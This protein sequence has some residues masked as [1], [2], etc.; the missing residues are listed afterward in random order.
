MREVEFVR[1]REKAA[2]LFEQVAELL[3]GH[4]EPDAAW[5]KRLA[6]AQRLL[7]DDARL[8]VVFTGEFSAGKTSL[9]S[10]LTGADLAIAAGPTTDREHTI[11]WRGLD[12]VDTPGVQADAQATDHDEI[13]RR[14]TVDAD[15]VLFVVT[16]ELFN[17]RLANYFRF[18]AGDGLGLAEKMLVVVNKI[19]REIN[20]DAVIATEVADAIRPHTDVPILLCS[21]RKFLDSLAERGDFA[22]QLEARSRIA[23]LVDALDAFVRSRGAAARLARP[24][25][26]LEELLDEARGA[27]VPPHASERRVAELHRRQLRI[28]QQARSEFEAAVRNGASTVKG[29]IVSRAEQAAG[30][31]AQGMT[32]ADLEALFA[33]QID[34]AGP[35]VARAIDELAT[36]IDAVVLRTGEQL[37]EL[38]GSELDTAVRTTLDVK[39]VKVWLEGG[40]AEPDLDPRYARAARV[41]MDGVKAGLEGAAKNAKGIGQGVKAVGKRVFK[42]K[43]KPHQAANAGKTAAKWAGHAGKALPFLAAALDYYI[44]HQEERAEAERERQLARSRLALRKAFHA[45]ADEQAQALREAANTHRQD[46]LDAWQAG[47][48]RSIADVTAAAAT[49]REFAERLS[50]AL[51]T[52][53]RMRAELARSA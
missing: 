5:A 21:A 9:I 8:R 45:Q 41:G 30:S 32:Q 7:E 13:A 49:Q 1:F 12:I 37:D 27:L 3:R 18:L 43:F 46:S 14:A 51:S 48:E 22:R 6:K 36:E 26:L 28:L 40:S 42:V 23:E 33:T 4:P 19:D 39:H 34:A 50:T 10:A 52:S 25:Q 31:V 53:R 16:N 2:A 20:E 17:D 44:A 47:I 15:L 35:A 29:A 38:E 11:S 24:L